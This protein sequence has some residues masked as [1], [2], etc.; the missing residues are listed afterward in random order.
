MPEA[1][2]IEFFANQLSDKLA[3]DNL[4]V[5][6]Y[7]GRVLGSEESIRVFSA[8]HIKG[9]EFEAVFM[10]NVSKFKSLYPSL[11]RQYAYIASLAPHVF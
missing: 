4:E 2:D 7:D 3:E 11:F 5:F 10:H 9:L 1:K 8:D 6:R